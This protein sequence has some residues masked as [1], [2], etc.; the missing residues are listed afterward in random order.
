MGAYASSPIHHG[1]QEHNAWLPEP[2]QQ[3]LGSEWTLAKEVVN[4]LWVMWPITVDLLATAL[5]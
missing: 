2:R 5:N 1:E 4:D 3:M